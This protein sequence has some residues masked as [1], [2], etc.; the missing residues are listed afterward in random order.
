ML[1]FKLLILKGNFSRRWKGWF[2]DGMD[3]FS[4]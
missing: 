2:Q 3:V 4:E 1:H